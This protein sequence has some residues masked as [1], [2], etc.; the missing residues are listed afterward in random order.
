[1]LL[2]APAA[3]LAASDQ[4]RGK[5]PAS[6]RGEALPQS[7]QWSSDDDITVASSASRASSAWLREAVA[8][9]TLDTVSVGDGGAE[10]EREGRGSDI[11]GRSGALGEEGGVWKKSKCDPETEGEGTRLAD[12]SDTEMD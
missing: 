9:A 10:K 11:P 1:M 7:V 12:R 3:G 5:G 6:T 2:D 8:G 4:T